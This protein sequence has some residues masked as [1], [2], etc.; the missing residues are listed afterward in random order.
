MLTTAPRIIPRDAA[1]PAHTANALTGEVPIWDARRGTLWWTDIQGQRLLAHEPATGRNETYNLPS[2]AGLIA[3]RKDGSLLLGLEDGLYPFEP[4]GGL[5]SRL[6]AVE[7]DN[8]NTRIND[9]K[10]DPVGRLWFGTMNKTG[11][12]GPVGAIYRLDPDGKLDVVRRDVTVPN[13]FAFSPDGGTLYFSDSITGTIEAFP[14]DVQT[15]RIGA[16]RPFVSYSGEGRCDGACIDAEGALWVAVVGGGR[17]ERYLAD[18]SLDM[19]VALPVSRPTMPMLGGHDGRTLYITS[20][21]RFLSA[22][23]LSEEPFAGD[24]L[25]V[26]VDVSGAGQNLAAI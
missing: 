20:Q 2:M 3:L 10:V 23:R 14:Y 16:G 26:R 12:G 25:A 19:V 1:L 22:Q 9:G 11:P 7:D 18:G 24:L 15:G 5:G 4:A 17:V 6:V 21:R 8:P 13:A